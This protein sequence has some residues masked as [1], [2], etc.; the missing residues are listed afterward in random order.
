MCVCEFWRI[1]FST[2]IWRKSASALYRDSKEQYEPIVW[3]LLARQS[4]RIALYYRDTRTAY[5]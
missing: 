4:A 5:T 3:L 1:P 2:E